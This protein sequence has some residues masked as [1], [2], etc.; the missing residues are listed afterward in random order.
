MKKG[1]SIDGIADADLTYS[2]F[3][4]DFGTAAPSD[5]ID[6][7]NLSTL[8][9]IYT[10]VSVD[11]T[12]CGTTCIVS[13]LLKNLGGLSGAIAPSTVTFVM[14]STASGAVLGTCQTQVVPDVGFNATTTVGCTVAMSGQPSSAAL[15][16]ATASNPGRG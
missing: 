7:S 16:T 3:G 15:V 12:R 1:V 13:A 14:T 5:V 2:N 4:K 6:F 10:V 11:T 9:P 8:P